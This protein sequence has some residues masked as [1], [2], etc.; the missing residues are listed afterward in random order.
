[1]PRPEQPWHVADGVGPE[2]FTPPALMAAGATPR[3][4]DCS[5]VYG[6]FPNATEI[7]TISSIFT[8]ALLWLTS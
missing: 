7:C 5:G 6:V 4:E 1:M 3:A 2:P 8:S